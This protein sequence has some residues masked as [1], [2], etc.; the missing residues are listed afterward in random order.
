ML[1]LSRQV[2]GVLLPPRWVLRGF[3]QGLHSCPLCAS[4]QRQVHTVLPVEERGAEHP[5]EQGPLRL[6]ATRAPLGTSREGD[7]GTVTRPLPRGS[8]GL[9]RVPSDEHPTE[10][11]SHT[12]QAFTRS[13][14][15]LPHLPT[16]KGTCGAASVFLTQG[17]R[18]RVWDPPP[19]QTRVALGAEHMLQNPGVV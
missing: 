14:V 1:L 19:S 11:A 7:V 12:P 6:G 17:N 4:L 16:L 18:G 3:L 13:Q 10:A 15:A 8:L 2:Q 5:C 9:A